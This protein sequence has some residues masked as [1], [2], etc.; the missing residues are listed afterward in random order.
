LNVTVLISAK[1]ITI[2]HA[3]VLKVSVDG[4]EIRTNGAKILL[5]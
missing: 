5:I 2:S 4:G 3:E 1:R